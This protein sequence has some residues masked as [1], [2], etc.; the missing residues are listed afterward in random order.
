MWEQGTFR[1]CP[2]PAVCL[3]ANFDAMFLYA[4]EG[5]DSC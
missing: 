1:R 3:A 4:V 5:T 2:L